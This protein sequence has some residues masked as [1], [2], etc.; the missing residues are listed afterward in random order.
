MKTRPSTAPAPS[1]R[2]SPPA[3]DRKPATAAADVAA[4][5]PP[6]R[7]RNSEATRTAILDAAREQFV[8]QGYE[9]TSVRAIAK[10][11]GIDAALVIR[12][13]GS[14]DELYTL[15]MTRLRDF[16]YLRRVPR[17]QLGAKLV[18]DLVADQATDRVYHVVLGMLRSAT[19]NRAGDAGRGVVDDHY[20]YPLSKRLEG[21]HAEVR[22]ALISAIGFG[23]IGM[24]RIFHSRPLAGVDP[25]LIVELLAPAIQ[26][27]VDGKSGAADSGSGPDSKS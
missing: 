16:S 18:D 15:A 14:K 9:A 24:L 8:Q 19:S 4:A 22:A 2:S 25:A 26:A 10:A 17:T 12:Y 23:L 27:L 6:V 13:F 1:K 11:A 5:V 3:R 7:K 20:V 21:E